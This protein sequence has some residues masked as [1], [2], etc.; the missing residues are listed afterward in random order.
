LSIARE[1][2]AQYLVG[3]VPTVAAADGAAWRT[4]QLRVLRPGVRVRA[5]EG[6]LAR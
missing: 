2:R 3:Y 1:L 6:Y 4:I 5:R